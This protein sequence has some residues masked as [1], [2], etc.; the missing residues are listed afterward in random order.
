MFVEHDTLFGT[1]INLYRSIKLLR[2]MESEVSDNE[3][4]LT[5]ALS[6]A[7]DAFASIMVTIADSV[8]VSTK[9]KE[10]GICI[11]I[12]GCECLVVESGRCGIDPSEVKCALSEIFPMLGI[13]ESNSFI[14]FC[15]KYVRPELEKYGKSITKGD[16]ETALNWV[17]NFVFVLIFRFITGEGFF[18]S[19]QQ[20]QNLHPDVDI[21]IPGW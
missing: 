18:E 8:I 16:A 5:E 2:S 13:C 3:G 4:R 11:E 10:Y 21:R 14:R 9:S 20:I 1:A 7:T 19:L 15:D 17:W 6:D 12:S